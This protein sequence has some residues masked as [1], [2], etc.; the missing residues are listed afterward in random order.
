MKSI[1]IVA[2]A[3]AILFSVVQPEM[4]ERTYFLGVG[5]IQATLQNMSIL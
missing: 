2:T 4:Y 1:A 3:L 5:K